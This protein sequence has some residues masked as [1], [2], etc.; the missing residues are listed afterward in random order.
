MRLFLALD[1][2]D[3]ARSE[4]ARWRDALIGPGTAGLR[5]VG[6]AALHVTLVFLGS[7]PRC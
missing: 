6:E 7:K 3:G 1:L 5:P 2:S 4:V